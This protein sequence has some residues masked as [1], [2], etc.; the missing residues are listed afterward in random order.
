MRY[1]NTVQWAIAAQLGEVYRGCA[2]ATS[3]DELIAKLQ[4]PLSTWLG[5]DVV[6]LALAE[7]PAVIVSSVSPITPEFS[8]RIQAHG[9]RCIEGKGK[10]ARSAGDITIQQVGTVSEVD[11]IDSDTSILW[12]GALESSGRLIAVVTFYRSESHQISPLE[13]TALRQI[14]SLISDT[15]IRILETEAFATG[16]EIETTADSEAPSDIVV[17]GIKDAALVSQAFGADR[18]RN[19]QNEMIARLSITQP[20]AFLI[21]RLGFDRIIIINHP[22]TG[23]TIDKWTRECVKSCTEIEVAPG[24]SLEISVEVGEVEG[25]DPSNT[26]S[27]NKKIQEIETPTDIGLDVLAG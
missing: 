21:A 8:E 12:T 3:V 19:I 15:L 13:L 5:I 18:V 1:E 11:A 10:T 9:A 14:R 4:G 6:T 23:M 22:G 2:N 27:T 25:N 7:R 20:E 16:V 17:I 26:A 24:V